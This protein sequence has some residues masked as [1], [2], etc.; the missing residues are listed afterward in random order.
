VTLSIFEISNYIRGESVSELIV[1]LSHRDDFVNVNLDVMFP[2]MPC[3]ILSLDVHD[4]L[5]THKTDVMGDIKKH[6]LDKDGIR[7][8]TESALDRNV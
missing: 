3:D 8:S 4:I 6:R 1:D 7:I 2:F 5:G